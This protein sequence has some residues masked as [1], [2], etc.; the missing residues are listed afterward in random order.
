KFGGHKAAGGFSLP[1]ENLPEFRLRL[2]EFAN[3]CLEIQHL[4]P[5]LKIDTQVNLHDIN[6]EDLFQQLNI[7]HPCG[8]DNSDPIFWTPNVQVIEQKIVGKG[9]IK[10]TVVQN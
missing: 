3:N 4:K 6:N 7:L 10:L 5:L 2:S 1:A 9:H 8:I